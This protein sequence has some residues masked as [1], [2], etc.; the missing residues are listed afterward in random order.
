MAK[1]EKTLRQNRVVQEPAL[2]SAAGSERV[3]E[4][5]ASGVM[6]QI[7]DRAGCAVSTVS[8]VIN[9]KR[10]NFSVR[11]AMEQKILQLAMELDYQPNPFLQSMR[12]GKSKIVGIFDFFHDGSS[13]MLQSKG[14]F[15]DGIQE[16]GYLPVGRYVHLHRLY[17]YSVPFPIVGALL[18]NISSRQFLSFFERK[19]IPYVVINGICLDNGSAVQIDEKANANLLIGELYRNGHRK[20]A[21][22]AAHHDAGTPFQHYSGVLRQQGFDEEIARLGLPAPEGDGDAIKQPAAFLRHHVVHNGVTA[23]ICYDH[24]R[25]LRLMHAAVELKLRIPEDFSLICYDDAPE[26]ELLTPSVTGCFFDS[27]RIGSTAARLLVERMENDSAPGSR[28]VK[29]PGKLML[30]Q[31]VAALEKGILH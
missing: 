10:K 25:V 11:P 31:S 21:Y 19:A 17:E 9:G 1:R 22:Y 29:I 16:A 30:R 13:I 26:L 28:V 18:F 4:E 8:R 7:A 24:E 14:E 2:L 15:I 27:C 23:V 12:G 3:R 20:I 6:K 5:S